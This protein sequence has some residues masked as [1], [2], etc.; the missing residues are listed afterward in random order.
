MKQ[1]ALLLIATGL[2]V[3]MLQ[4]CAGNPVA[5]GGSDMPN[6]AAIA[7]VV[8][9]I[10][11]DPAPGQTVNLRRIVLTAGGDSIMFERSEQSDAHGAFLFDSI[12][13]G[14]Y[15]LLCR[16]SAASR[17]AIAQRLPARCGD[18]LTRAL[19]LAPCVSLVG[20][21]HV[22][23]MGYAEDVQVFIPGYGE[24]ASTK[25]LGRYVLQCVPQGEYDIAY[26]FN[27]I[28][29]LTHIAIQAGAGDLVHLRDVQIALFDVM[30]ADTVSRYE[31][32]FVKSYYVTPRF[33]EQANF[34]NWYEGIDFGRVTYHSVIDGEFEQW[35]DQPA[36]PP[37]YDSVLVGMLFRDERRGV[38]MAQ[39]MGDTIC[40]AGLESAAPAQPVYAIAAVRASDAGVDCPLTVVELRVVPE[41]CESWFDQE[42]SFCTP[43]VFDATLRRAGAKRQPPR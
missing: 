7:G 10:H 31:H 24:I 11:G 37:A 1:A 19:Q 25:T 34:P 38:G 39:F 18:T 33:Y 3:A 12:D 40:L 21:V 14:E 35:L 32:Q 22:P 17:G 15:T 43:M 30:A 20:H 6:G 29:N 16:D 41:M 8:Y 42:F 13:S 5:G 28:V 2:I 4:S 26:A 36:E 9:D 23:A 27:G